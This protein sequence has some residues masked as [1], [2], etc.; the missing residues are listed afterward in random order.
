[1][2]SIPVGVFF[3]AVINWIREN[4]GFV[5]DAIDTVLDFASRTRERILLLDAGVV[6]P[7]VVAALLAG[8]IGYFLVKKAPRKIRLG[9]GLA[10]VA[11]MG[12][13][14]FWRQQT[15]EAEITVA[16]A[17]DLADSLE[18]YR[19]DLEKVAPPNYDRVEAV[20]ADA[21]KL[22]PEDRQYVR[23]LGRIERRLGR[24]GPGEFAD[25]ADLV[26]DVRELIEGDRVE[27]EMTEELD[28]LIAENQAYFVSLSGIEESQSL[29]RRFGNLEEPQRRYG[30]LNQR[31]HDRTLAFLDA[32]I[33]NAAM[34]GVSGK[35]VEEWEQLRN[36]VAS[37]NP[38]KIALYPPIVMIGLL[39]SEE[40]TS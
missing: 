10:G 21:E 18:N 6:C 37:L 12:G 32:S 31:T 40:Q 23:H 34:L 7:A 39:R 19:D 27:V 5:L 35:T 13:L 11:L 16:E 30:V 38:Q 9:L 28:V 1:M 4:V 8:L 25:A 24:M 26:A 17:A 15:L 3:E 36:R 22:A 33:A 20:L 14:G 29:I 2:W